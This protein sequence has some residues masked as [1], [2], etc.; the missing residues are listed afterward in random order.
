MSGIIPALIA[1]FRP[2]ANL[3]EFRGVWP[4]RTP[5]PPSLS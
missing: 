2:Y 1:V 4:A 5:T 3:A